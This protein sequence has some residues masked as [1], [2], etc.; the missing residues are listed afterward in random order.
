ME[1]T[2]F[3]FLR[4]SADRVEQADAA[5]GFSR[6]FDAHN[7]KEAFDGLCRQVVKAHLGVDGSPTSIE[8]KDTCRLGSTE[9]SWPGNTMLFPMSSSSGNCNSCVVVP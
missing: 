1:T 7:Q 3:S 6:S 8:M 9:R 5:G 2:L 4:R